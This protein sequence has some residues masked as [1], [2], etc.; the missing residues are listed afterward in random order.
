ME[1]NLIVLAGPTASGKTACGIALAKHFN[2]EI[3]SSDSRQIY[4]ETTIGTAVPDK[5][6]RE[7]IKHHFIQ[8]ISVKQ[9]YNA[10]MYEEEVL[11]TLTTL[12]KKHDVVIL[13]GGSGLYIDAVCTGIDELP[14]I[15]PDI[16]KNLAERLRLEG[17]DKLT[18][19]LKRVDPVSYRIVDLK[20]PMRVLKALE[21]SVQTGM[22]YS[23]FLKNRQK[24]REFNIIRLALDMDRD[25]LYERINSRVDEMMKRGLLDEVKD[26]LPVRDYTA[27][28]TLGYRELFRHIDGEISLEEAIEQIKNSSRKYA[29]KQ[30]TWFRKGSLYQWFDPSDLAGMIAYIES[31]LNKSDK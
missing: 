10:S 2:T 19:E 30:L 25:Q 18:E 7:K 16:R 9:D 22:P 23:G 21:I 29:R 24:V 8:T 17:L 27:L 12:F 15:D 11:K 20:N 31:S 1:K 5:E 3:I 26:L 28:K 13:A 4:K 6:E 14:K